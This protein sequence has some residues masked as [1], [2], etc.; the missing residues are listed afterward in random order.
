MLTVLLASR[1]G[2]DDSTAATHAAV[3]R[4]LTFALLSAGSAA[5]PGLLGRCCR[6]EAPCRHVSI[7]GG[8][9]LVALH[10]LHG[11]RA[12]PAPAQGKADRRRGGAAWHGAA[13]ASTLPLFF[14][15]NFVR[16]ASQTGQTKVVPRISPTRI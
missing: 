3:R 12:A 13:R 9:F 7:V 1:R 8:R 16:P 15:V 5:E 11:V 10:D 2:E 14:D 4:R 6:Q